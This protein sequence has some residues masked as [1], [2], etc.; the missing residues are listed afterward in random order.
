VGV[1][2]YCQW[3]VYSNAVSGLNAEMYCNRSLKFTWALKHIS[4]IYIQ[5][6][7]NWLFRSQ[8]LT[9]IFSMWNFPA[10]KGI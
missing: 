2:C 3:F 6:D 5:S 8:L 4:V 7:H 10:V 1:L 9:V